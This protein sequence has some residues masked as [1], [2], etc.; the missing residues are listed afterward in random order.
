MSKCPLHTPEPSDAHY[1]QVR[2]QRLEHE[3][4][5]MLS[6][7]RCHHQVRHLAETYSLE[8]FSY[9]ASLERSPHR[10][11]DHTRCAGHPACIAYNTNPATY[12]TRHTTERCTCPTVFTPYHDLISI[13]RQGEIPLISIETSGPDTNR[14]YKLKAHQRS[15]DSEYI[16]V[17]HVWA[18]GLGNPNGN[19]LPLC[20]IKRLSATL[21]ILG[22]LHERREVNIF[23]DPLSTSY[24]YC[25][26]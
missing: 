12:K 21:D 16:A 4:D 23:D 19:G 1:D 22:V 17:S 15:K 6:N 14:A 20:Q 9:L 3:K 13:L 11:A 24:P 18:D 10:L 5:K 2:H 25:E 26:Y 7:G 8:T